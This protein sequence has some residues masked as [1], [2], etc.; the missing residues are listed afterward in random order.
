MIEVSFFRMMFGLEINDKFNRLFSRLFNITENWNCMVVELGS[1]VE[2]SWKWQLNWRKYFCLCFWRK[3]GNWLCNFNLKPRREVVWMWSFDHSG[4][5]DFLLRQRFSLQQ[6]N[7]QIL[8]PVFI[9]FKLAG[10]HFRFELWQLTLGWDF[11]TSVT[12]W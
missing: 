7:Q 2:N 3:F 12:R 11:W 9:C 5:Y 10:S 4:F 6:P 1:C 8:G